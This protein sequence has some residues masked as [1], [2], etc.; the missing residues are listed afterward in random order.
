MSYVQV[1]YD[2][3]IKW[4]HRFSCESNVAA[5]GWILSDCSPQYLFNDIVSLGETSCHAV[6]AKLQQVVPR[7]DMFIFGSECD[8]LPSANT[9]TRLPA[10]IKSGQ[11]KSGVTTAGGFLYDERRRPLLVIV[12]NVANLDA[13]GRFA[14]S[15][16]TTMIHMCDGMGYDVD[17][18]IYTHRRLRGTSD[19]KALLLDRDLA[20]LG[21]CR[22]V[23]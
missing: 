5:Q 18:H 9:S 6:I 20:Q 11:G 8:N 4:R 1:V 14:D 23:C 2:V 16:K 17:D 12:E 21:V 13:G 19:K 10:C 15:D 3:T 22:P 7:V